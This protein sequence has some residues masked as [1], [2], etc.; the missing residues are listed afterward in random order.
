MCVLVPPYVYQS[1]L[2]CAPVTAQAVTALPTQTNPLPHAYCPQAASIQTFHPGS[3]TRLDSHVTPFGLRRVTST[4]CSWL[5]GTATSR[6]RDCCSRAR[7]RSTLLLNHRS[8]SAP[9]NRSINLHPSLSIYRYQH[10]TIYHPF[11][12]AVM[13]FCCHIKRLTRPNQSN[14]ASHCPAPPAVT[15]F[16]E[17]C[18]ARAAAASPPTRI[19]RTCHVHPTACLMSTSSIY[20]PVIPSFPIRHLYTK[21]RHI[22]I[23]PT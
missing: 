4:L 14:T 10:L 6:W 1:C 12:L 17:H 18:T 13:V 21:S 7:P 9:I 15:S 22:T 3:A 23:F 2:P 16:V 5:P 19:S 8:I 20:P 11:L